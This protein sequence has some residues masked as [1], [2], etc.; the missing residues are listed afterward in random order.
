[1]AIDLDE[2]DGQT[3]LDPDEKAVATSAGVIAQTSQC[4]W[5]ITRSGFNS[6]ITSR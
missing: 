3:A 1:M 5:V 6:R 2:Q 4:D